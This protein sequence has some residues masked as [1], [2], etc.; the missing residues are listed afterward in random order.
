[1]HSD[2]NTNAVAHTTM[3]VPEKRTYTVDEVA[4]LLQISRSKSYELCRE[5]HFKIIKVGRSVRISKASFDE[6]LE[7]M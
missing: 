2:N 5:G 3:L 1:M 4:E 6:W 7:A